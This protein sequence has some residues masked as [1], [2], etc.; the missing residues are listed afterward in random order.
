VR[1]HRRSTHKFV[2]NL[3]GGRGKGCLT[4]VMGAHPS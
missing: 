3:E 4:V 1:G 2:R